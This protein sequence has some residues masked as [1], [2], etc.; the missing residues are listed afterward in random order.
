MKNLFVLFFM[1][2]A[3][4]FTTIKAQ[5][6]IAVNNAV[7]SPANAELLHWDHTTFEFGDLTQNVPAKATFTVTNNSTEPMLLKEVKPTCGC[8]VAAYNQD[9]ILPGESTVIT[10]TYNAKK[11]GSFHKTIKVLTNLSDDPISLKL[12]G[13]VIKEKM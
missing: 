7:E 12:K 3:V 2:T 4:S 13:Q 6:A 10:T 5:N 11:E 8:T 9:P 1:L